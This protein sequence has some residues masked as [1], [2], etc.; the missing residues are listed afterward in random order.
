MDIVKQLQQRAS[1]EPAFKAVCER[2]SKRQRARGRVTL[3]SLYQVMVR[4]KYQYSKREYEAV[5]RQLAAMGVGT[6][7]NNSRGNLKALGSITM[8]LQSIGQAALGTAEL[9]PVKFRKPYKRK[10][11]RDPGPSYRKFPNPPY[12]TSVFNTPPVTNTGH[13]VVMHMTIDGMPLRLPLPRPISREELAALI[14]SFYIPAPGVIQQAPKS[15]K[16]I[17]V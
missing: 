9:K 8:S 16:E 7:E 5:L 10:I 15:K 14:A 13:L 12:P 2:F 4:D 6:V 3:R 17:E 11:I 1:T